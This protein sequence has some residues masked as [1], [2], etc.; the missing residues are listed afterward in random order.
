MWGFFFGAHKMHPFYAC[1]LYES[2]NW[3]SFIARKAPRM[4]L[5]SQLYLDCASP[6]AQEA[7]TPLPKYCY[8]DLPQRRQTRDTPGG[9]STFVPGFLTSQLTFIPRG[10]KW[11]H[12]CHL[13]VSNK[14][15]WSKFLGLGTEGYP[16]WLCPA[17]M[18]SPVSPLLTS[19]PPP[20]LPPAPL[21]GVHLLVD[22]AL[23]SSAE[24]MW[25]FVAS[26]LWCCG[27]WPMLTGV[28]LFQNKD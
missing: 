12:L 16:I 6:G 21:L 8:T 23:L 1:Q 13:L 22:P 9:L 15:M 26:A 11:P 2:E 14:G 3:F 17:A 19:L 5:L 28:F 20:R 27:P 4:E 7:R 25:I 10:I 24:Q 18:S